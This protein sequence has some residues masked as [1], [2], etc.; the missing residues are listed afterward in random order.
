MASV[1]AGD[2]VTIS[3]RGTLDDGSVFDES[4][5]DEPLR[6]VAG[7][8]EVIEGLTNAVIGMTVG[9]KKRIVIEPDQAYGDYDDELEQTVERSELPEDAE[10][11]DQ[12][13]ATAVDNDDEEFP[14]WVVELNETEAVLDANHPL[15][16]ETLIFEIELLGINEPEPS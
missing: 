6:F 8:E 12:L 13:T 2:M 7:G 5:P 9:E 10:V 4:T 3:Y 14:V 15:A 11:G 1:V 16:G